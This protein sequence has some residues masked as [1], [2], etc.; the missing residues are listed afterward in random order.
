MSVRLTDGCI[1]VSNW[2]MFFSD[3]NFDSFQ[4]SLDF[5]FPS[6]AILQ[7]QQVESPVVQLIVSCVELYDFVNPTL[8]FMRSYYTFPES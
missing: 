2:K 7:G 5:S 3:L 6:Q 4:Q 1:A 8:K